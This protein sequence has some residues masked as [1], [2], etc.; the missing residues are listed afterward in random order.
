VEFGQLDL[1]ICTYMAY[2]VG[3]F[4]GGA[5]ST[6]PYGRLFLNLVIS[7]HAPGRRRTRNIIK[8]VSGIFCFSLSGW[9]GRGRRRPR[10]I[11]KFVSDVFCFS[12]PGNV[13]SRSS[14]WSAWSGT[15]SRSSPLRC[16]APSDG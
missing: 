10:K 2:E 12:P 8:F 7:H 11:I 13:R 1:D 4:A 15:I 3:G 6:R 14:S 9:R 16:R 5:I